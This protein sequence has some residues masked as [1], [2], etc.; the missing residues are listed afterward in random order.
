MAQHQQELSLQLGRIE[1]ERDL[2]KQ[3]LEEQKVDAQKHALIVRIDEW[4]RD[5]INKIKEMAAETRQAVRSHI[6]DYLTQMESKLNPLTEQIRQIRNDDDILD[7]DIKKWKEELKQL[8]ALLDN[9]FLLRIQQDAA[10]LVTK[11]C[12]EVCGSS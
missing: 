8:N 12:L 2:F 11:I 4:E 5:S 1:V 10:P 7:T 3:K 6:V 9:P